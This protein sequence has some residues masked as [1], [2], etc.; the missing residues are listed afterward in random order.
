MASKEGKL[1]ASIWLQKD[2]ETVECG[3]QGCD[4]HFAMSR[5]FYDETQ[6]KG[7]TWYCPRGHPRVWKGD[8]TEE[9]LRKAKAR[10]R[11][12]EDQLGAAEADSEATRQR[13]IRDRHRFA[14]GVCPCCNRSFT[15]LA[16]HMKT[17]HPE[18]DPTDLRARGTPGC[19]CSCG[20]VFDTIQGLRVHQG[21]SRPFDWTDPKRSKWTRHLTVVGNV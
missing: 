6:R 9:Q 15:A 10:E 13:L 7:S 8:T 16:R 21:R 12:L 4:Q 14:H 19:E 18:Y 20:R 2:Y 1:M 3:A 17:K 11:H 5:H